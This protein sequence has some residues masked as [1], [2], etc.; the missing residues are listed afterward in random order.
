[1]QVSIKAMC[2]IDMNSGKY[3]GHNDTFVD[4][5]GSAR[6][7]TNRN[8]ADR[9]TRALGKKFGCRLRVDYQ[10]LNC[11]VQVPYED[12]H[13]IDLSKYPNAKLALLYDGP[14]DIKDPSKRIH[15]YMK[16]MD[17]RWYPFCE[18]FSRTP[19]LFD[20][21]E[22]IEEYLKTRRFYVEPHSELLKSWAR[23]TYANANEEMKN[24]VGLASVFEGK[25][26]IVCIMQ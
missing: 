4:Y 7:F 20:S 15:A 17:M 11:D 21:M 22:E 25:D 24:T 18:H 26:I 16:G 2:L 23:S 13:T 12:R 10:V 14:C 6:I 8:V 9:K 5:F 1:M 3:L 19:K